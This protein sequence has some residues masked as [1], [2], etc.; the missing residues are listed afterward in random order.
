MLAGAVLVE[1]GPAAGAGALALSGPARAR[2]RPRA[3]GR[4]PR[5]ECAPLLFALS[6]V[7]LFVLFCFAESG[8]AG[9]DAARA[10]PRAAPR[11]GGQ[12]SGPRSSSRSVCQECDRNARRALL[13]LEALRVRHGPAL[14]SDLPI[15]RPDWEEAVEAIGK[16]ALEEQ[17]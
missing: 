16:M 15:P 2:A 8:Q 10:R 14:A 5:G 1:H 12:Q 3:A 17:R 6:H 4:P 7:L 9:A 11:Q 13:A